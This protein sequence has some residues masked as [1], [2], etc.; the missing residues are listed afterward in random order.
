[1][2]NASQL[3]E[4]ADSLRNTEG[5][6]SGALEKIQ[7]VIEFDPYNI[8]VLARRATI[9]RDRGMTTEALATLQQAISYCDE[10]DYALSAHLLRLYADVLLLVGEF[11]KARMQAEH[12]YSKA[13]IAEIPELIAYTL[14]TSGMIELEDKE[15]AHARVF[16]EKAKD[17][18]DAVRFIECSL[19]AEVGLM[20]MAL[21]N[22]Q[23]PADAIA[24]RV[25][26][27]IPRVQSR[28]LTVWF[29]ALLL[30]AECAVDLDAEMITE[31][32]NAYSIAANNG[33]VIYHADLAYALSM[34]VKSKNT[35]V[36]DEYLKIAEHLFEKAKRRSPITSN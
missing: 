32:K 3:L 17:Q 25:E 22:N 14:Y 20:R 19:R 10:D 21:A 28:W 30:R 2:V 23:E 16:L 5:N 15:Y 6:L 9:E 27:L 36:A 12:A 13:Q 1:M 34:I 7:K 31:I 8:E 24:K 18:A 29:D 4:E 35:E 11:D 26:V 33:W